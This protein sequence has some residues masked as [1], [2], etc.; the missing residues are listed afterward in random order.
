MDDAIQF[1][2]ESDI[3]AFQQV[4]LERFGIELDDSTAKH[5]LTRLVRLVALIL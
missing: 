4:Y 2:R 3:T 1:I 5:E